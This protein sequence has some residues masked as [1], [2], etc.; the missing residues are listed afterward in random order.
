VLRAE[1]SLASLERVDATFDGDS[2]R[3]LAPVEHFGH[4]LLLK[5]A[6]AVSR[7]RVEVAGLAAALVGAPAVAPRRDCEQE[8]CSDGGGDDRD[9][10]GHRSFSF[11]SWWP[12]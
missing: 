2:E 6:R 10:P 8:S 3:P 9:G 5:R 7:V 11:C 12:S 1:R 4:P